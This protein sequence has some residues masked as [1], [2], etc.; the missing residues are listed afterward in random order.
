MA[1]KNA[2]DD[3]GT[4]EQILRCAALMF[5]QEGYAAVTLRNIAKG[6]GLTTGSFYYHFQSKEEIVSEILDQGHRRCLLEVR[7]AVMALGPDAST[8][9]ILKTAILMHISCLHGEDNFPSANI[10]IFALVPVEIRT[11]SL[12]IRHEYERYWVKLLKSCQNR[13]D[14]KLGN[15]PAV[16]ANIL[17]GAMN[18]SLEWYKPKRHKIETIAET[19]VELVVETEPSRNEELLGLRTTLRRQVS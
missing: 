18:W 5:R 1:K 12:S 19:L 17:F 2:G 10:R 6:V 3:V 11:A 14:S 16:L 8:R 13:G 4:R 7:R 9:L 15:D